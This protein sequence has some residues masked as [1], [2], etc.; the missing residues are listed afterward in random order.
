MFTKFPRILRD[1]TAKRSIISCNFNVGEAWSFE[2]RFPL[3]E[4]WAEDNWEQ[5]WRTFSATTW[6]T[7]PPLPEWQTLVRENILQ[8]DDSERRRRKP[9]K[10][11]WRDYSYQLPT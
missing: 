5:E 2:S 9:G 11:K 8:H 3:Y 6:Q 4:D 10:R 1:V 7:K